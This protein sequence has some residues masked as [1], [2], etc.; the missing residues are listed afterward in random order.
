MSCLRAGRINPVWPY[1]K[2]E[3]PEVKWLAQGSQLMNSPKPNPLHSK[4]SHAS[5]S[6]KFL[7]P[8]SGIK[9]VAVSNEG[10]SHVSEVVLPISMLPGIKIIKTSL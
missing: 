1:G 2:T 9:D 8:Q 4:T 5:T 7:H 3:A 6:A 10:L